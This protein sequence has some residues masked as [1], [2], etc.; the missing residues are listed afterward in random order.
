MKLKEYQEWTKNTC[1]KL[2]NQVLDTIHMLMGMTTEVGELTDCFKKQLAYN[3][4]IDFINVAE[5]IGDI[6]FYIASFCRINNLDLENI[7]E[8]N[9][10]KLESR[11]P[12]K[13]TEYHAINRDLKKERQI[14]EQ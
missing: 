12:E 6:M 13:F 8:T 1:A 11:Y 9:A 14:L 10:K 5:E 3:K 7:I 4:E 2:D